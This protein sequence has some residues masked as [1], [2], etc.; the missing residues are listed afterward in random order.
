MLLG[1]HLTEHIELHRVMINLRFPCKVFIVITISS[2]S[3]ELKKIQTRSVELINNE[4]LFEES[5]SIDLP[6]IAKS[7][8]RLLE[9]QYSLYIET[10]NGVK[11]A[12]RLIDS[13]SVEQ[14]RV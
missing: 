5:F 9:L 8:R 14:A 2:Q 10:K 4:A 7:K 13:F 12:G 1:G 11:L 6:E 3:K